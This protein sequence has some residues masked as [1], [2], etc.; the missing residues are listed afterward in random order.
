MA[1]ERWSCLGTKGYRLNVVFILY[2]SCVWKEWLSCQESKSL[3][4]AYQENIDAWLRSFCAH[5]A[6]F[7]WNVGKC[8]LC[9]ESQHIS[10]ETLRYWRITCAVASSR[11]HICSV[12]RSGLKIWRFN[13]F[14][15]LWPAK[16][17]RKCYI[18]EPWKVEF[19]SGR[20]SYNP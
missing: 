4:S 18:T 16:V 14:L 7:S 12:D 3:N 11:R 19:M 5:P 20:T 2:W 8:S 6:V 17:R 13:I 15:N 10:Y 1:K 9:S